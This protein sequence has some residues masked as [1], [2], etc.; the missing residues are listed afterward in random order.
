MQ[1]FFR[2]QISETIDMKSLRQILP[3]YCRVVRY[4]NLKNVKTLSEALR[5]KQ[6]LIVLWNIH[7][8]QHRVLNQPGHFF[9]ISV[10]GPERCIVFSSTGMTPKQELFLT[11]S[12]PLAL[13][14]ILPKGT[15]YNDK[16]FQISNDSNTCWRWL[17]LFSH[18]SKMGLKRFQQLFFK[19]HLHISDPD[20]LVVAMTHILVN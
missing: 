16:K 12:D 14:R 5:G 10:R 1:S 7:D 13:E 17:I 8:K 20:I 18:L 15:I 6:I 11:Q 4:D 19:P 2:K 3:P 9:L